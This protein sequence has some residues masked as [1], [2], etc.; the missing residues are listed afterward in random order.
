MRT[1]AFTLIEMLVVIA[2]L[3]ILATAATVSLRAATRAANIGDAVE[4]FVA[5]DQ[6]TREVAYRFNR[7][8]TLRFDLNHG[9]VRRIGD[10]DGATASPLVLGSGVRV[11]RVAFDGHTIGYGN[12]DVGFSIRGQSPTYA[13]QLTSASG[14]SRWVALAGL[15][16]QPL[17][18]RNE[19]DVLDI[20]PASRPAASSRADA[21]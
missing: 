3:A 2:L 6:G 14:E 11:S 21:R 13:V 19:S 10:S 9:T 15:T 7:Q 8:P 20:F 16:G 17:V 5:I 18:L 4:Q 1:R 12:V